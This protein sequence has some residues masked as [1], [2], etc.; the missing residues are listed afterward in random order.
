MSKVCIANQALKKISV[1]SIL[2]LTDN[3][4]EARTMNLIFDR[5][6]KDA[7]SLRS[8][9]FATT[10]TELGRLSTPPGSEFNYQYQLPVDSLRIVRIVNS[11]LYELEYKIEGT[12]LLTDE[13]SVIV[14]Y[15]KYITDFGTL[16]P[17]FTSYLI[18]ALAVEAC[19]D[20]TG[21]V[22]LQDRLENQM[23][24]KLIQAKKADAIEA[25]PRCKVNSTV[26]N[27]RYG[28]WR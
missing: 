11:N 22:S 6:Y 8:W 13:P 24:L 10:R 17:L 12:K 2:A 14:E 25:S 28:Y 15:I 21:N 3:S 4:K 5:V 18:L 19:F 1:S 20:L 7:L 16:P 23:A 26:I 27:R 9:N